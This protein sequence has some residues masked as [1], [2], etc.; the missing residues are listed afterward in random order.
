MNIKN[1]KSLANTLIKLLPIYI[2]FFTITANS[3]I[4]KGN[5]MFGGD[6]SF[7]NKERFN[8]NFKNDK[9]KTSEFDIKANA[10]YFFIDKLQAGIR[11]GYS[12]YKRTNTSSDVNRYLLNYGAYSRYYFLNPEKLVNIYLDGGY[13]FGSSAFENGELKDNTHGYSI[14]A[15]PTI[16]FNSSV[17]MEL[18]LNY[19][20][21][22]FKGVNDST[23]N[24]LQLSLGFQIFLTKK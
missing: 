1:L 17:A 13:F 6:A 19:S 9:L 20:S 11:V 22:K 5:W 7:S 15:G 18:G 21:E 10:G 12:D 23:E 14:S 16:F 24:N 3:Q 4:T 8:N 2:L